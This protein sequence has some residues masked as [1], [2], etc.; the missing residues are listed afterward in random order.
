MGVAAFIAGGHLARHVRRMRHIYK[1]RRH[2]L[3]TSLA[4]DLGKW[5]EPIPSFYG[6]HVAAVAR[7]AMDL[8]RVAETLLAQ[9]LK[10]HTLSRY[11]LETRTG[12]A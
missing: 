9:H 6:M 12:R 10:I 8:D 7:T 5:L 1:Q 2:L 4:A 3:L 11:Y